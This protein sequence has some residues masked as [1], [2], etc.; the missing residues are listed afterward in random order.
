MGRKSLTAIPSSVC[1]M[2]FMLSLASM[3]L[4]AEEQSPKVAHLGFVATKRRAA[5]LA[6]RDSIG[7]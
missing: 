7:R 4:H 3:G 1:C 5:N 6:W 2:L